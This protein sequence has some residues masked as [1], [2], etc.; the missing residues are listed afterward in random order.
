M[1]CFF[2]MPG[3]VFGDDSRNIGRIA[4]ECELIW[5]SGCVIMGEVYRKR[6]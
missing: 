4:K 2:D 3:M 1:K 5:C 6:F